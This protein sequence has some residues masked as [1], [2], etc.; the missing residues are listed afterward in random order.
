MDAIPLSNDE[1]IHSVAIELNNSKAELTRGLFTYELGIA[2]LLIITLVVYQTHNYWFMLP[3]TASIMLIVAMA[4]FFK[5]KKAEIRR[6]A[7]KSTAVEIENEP[8]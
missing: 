6:L 2:M 1:K 4:L 5:D 7:L 3:L 8:Q